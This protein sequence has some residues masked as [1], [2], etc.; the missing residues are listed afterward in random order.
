M[1][2]YIIG[3]RVQR[4]IHIINIIS[5]IATGNNEETIIILDARRQVELTEFEVYR[6]FIVF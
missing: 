2:V 6:V 1:F 3:N 5:N 4:V